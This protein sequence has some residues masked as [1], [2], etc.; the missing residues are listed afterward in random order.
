M[1]RAYARKK[2]SSYSKK[3]LVDAVAAVEHGATIYQAS[4]ERGIPLETLRRHVLG[5]T[6]RIGAGR[7]TVLSKDEEGLIARAI[8]YLARAGFPCD[9]RDLKDI[10]SS[11]AKSVGR[12]VP[13]ETAPGNDWIRGF[14]KRWSDELGC[15]KPELL[16]KARAEGLSAEVVSRFFEMYTELVQDNNLTP[17]RIFNLDETGLATDARAEKVFVS[18]TDRNAYLRAATCGK[19]TYSVLF[20]ASASGVFMPPFTVY[21]GLHLY[22][23]WT[24]GGPPG[25]VYGVTKSGWMEDSVFEHWFM[26][27][28]LAQVK[29]LTKPVLLIFDGHGSHLTYDTVHQAM[30]NDVIILCLPPNTSH[31]LQPLDVGLFKPLKTQWRQILKNWSRESR[32]KSVDKATFPALLAKL[33]KELNPAHVMA[34]FRGSGLYPVCAEKVKPRMVDAAAP[35]TSSGVEPASPARAVANAVLQVLSPPSSAATQAAMTNS[36]R[37]RRRVQAKQGE[38]LTSPEVLKRLQEEKEKRECSKRQKRK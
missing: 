22:E 23:S 25:A 12:Q 33:F 16:T 3:E 36:K 9:R 10:V 38:V 17:D 8:T 35:S 5:L 15:R 14:E 29:E 30:E 37:S 1:P 2:A 26:K 6:D 13:W 31:A 19:V 28:F 32:Q 20:C 18:K 27:V 34:G 11:F 24:N 4:K 21:K 7:P